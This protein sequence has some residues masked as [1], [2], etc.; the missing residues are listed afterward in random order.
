[1]QW[2]KFSKNIQH[3]IHP[4]FKDKISFD[5]NGGLSNKFT[6]LYDDKVFATYFCDAW[7]WRCKNIFNPVIQDDFGEA[8]KMMDQ[9]S[10]VEIKNK[11][12]KPEDVANMIMA[13]FNNLSI[14]EALNHKDKFIRAIA[15]MD[16]RCGSRTFQNID[17]ST[18]EDFLLRNI[19][20]LRK[21]LE[22]QK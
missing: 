16:R 8:L 4:L 17:Y 10:C 1:M 21:Y 14:K 22:G 11:L 19:Y 6:I 3:Y 18:E 5:F 9:I 15:L 12:Y 20:N 13:I 2:K 7:H